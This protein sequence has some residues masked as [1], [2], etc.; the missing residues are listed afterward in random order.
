MPLTLPDLDDRRY[1]DL[2]EEARSLLVSYAPALTNHNPSDPVVTLT[3]AFAYVTEV[4][5]FRL[6]N[7]TDASRI[8]FLKLLNDS[9][10]VPPKTAAELDA[11][12]RQTVLRLRSTDRAV[13]PE[14]FETLAFATDADVVRAHCISER[15][16]KVT[17]P[18]QKAA[19]APGHVS[20]VIVPRGT[21]DLTTLTDKVA[22]YL[23]P[24]RLLGTKVH[25]VGP[26][27]VSLRVRLTL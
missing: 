15:N 10:W 27:L 14:D 4:L 19:P 5:L 3:E 26:R 7:V 8:A 20:V 1:D 21:A 17:D 22:A 12:T 13:T 9:K 24:R 6:N 16:L 25:V 23:E 18:A 11:K 2:V